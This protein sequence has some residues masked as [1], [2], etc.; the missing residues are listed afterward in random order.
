MLFHIA[1]V[2]PRDPEG[3]LGCCNPVPT[4]VRQNLLEIHRSI[5]EAKDFT[6]KVLLQSVFSQGER[7]ESKVGAEAEIGIEAK[8]H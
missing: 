8:C 3:V 5:V 7:R 1:E 6:P 4:L 2:L